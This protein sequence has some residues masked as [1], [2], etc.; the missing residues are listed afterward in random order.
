MGGVC[1]IRLAIWGFMSLSG[2]YMVWVNSAEGEILSRDAH[3]CED[4]EECTLANVW[5]PHD[6]NLQD[7]SLH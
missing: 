5:Q 6:A 1:K 2:S 3:F 4:I 7:V